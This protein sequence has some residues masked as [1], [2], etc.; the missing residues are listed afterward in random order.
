VPFVIAAQRGDREAYA[1]LYRR[2]GKFVHAI[3]LARVPYDAAADLAQEVFLHGWAEIDTLRE[4]AAFGGWIGAMARRRA[5]DYRRRDGREV[6]LTDRYASREA[7]DITLAATEA[8]EAIR[9]LPETYR[10]T[11]TLRLIEGCS[12]SEI[13]TIIGL[14]PESVRVNLHRGFKLLRERLEGQR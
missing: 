12:G 11:L 4:P 1:E 2:F 7:P 8:L 3:L 10:E 13:A 5:I 14:T 6:E 9:T